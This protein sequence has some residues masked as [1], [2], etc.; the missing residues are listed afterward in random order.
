MKYKIYYISE[1]NLT[2]KSAYSI[3]V[4][5]MCEA[6]KKIGYKINLF[7]I[8]NK[9][10]PNTLKFY[11]IKNTFRIISIFKK[12]T[13]LNFFLRVIFSLKIINKTKHEKCIYLSRSIIFALIA[14][15]LN[16]KII[17]ELH[18]EITGF[19]NFLYN[20]LKLIKKIDS[21]NYIFLNKRLNLLYKVNKEKFI[22]L[23]DSVCIKDFLIKKNKKKNPHVFILVAFLKARA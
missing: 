4:M 10:T 18:H 13:N 1:L 8:H 19:S 2:S 16:K 15:F 9:K 22:V 23:D 21:L 11:N 5:K 12:K 20:F 17:L 7:T 3:H 14:A 6:I